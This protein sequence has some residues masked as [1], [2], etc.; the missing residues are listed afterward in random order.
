MRFRR[1]LAA[2]LLAF[3]LVSA[4][5]AQ[6]DAELQRVRD[7]VRAGAL[8]RNAL[9]EA[10]SELLERRYV[11]TLNRTLLSESLQPGEIQTMLDAARGLERIVQE[12]FDL[13][14]SRVQAGAVPPNVLQQARDRLNSARRQ[15][16]LA[17]TRASLVR[18]VERMAAAETYLEELQDEDQAYRF[19]GFE[20]WEQQILLEIGD[21]YRDAFG[22][23]PPVSAEGDTLLHRSL[24][25]DHTG[26]IDVAVHPDSD[27]GQF[28]T[29]LLESLGI[30]YI[31][32]R[33]AVPG[34][35]T[36]PHIHVGPPSDPIPPEE[37]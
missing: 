25:L 3:A 1:R 15:S 4:A 21:M 35:S 16:E 36:G 19:E 13:V 34:Q 20:D 10:E 24:G 2:T 32:F 31:A 27:E 6:D 22:T 30:P 12:R 8:P 37:P 17:R 14:L 23:D 28:L 18:Q 5:L 26:R 7:L 29:Y 11:E 33:S 9:A